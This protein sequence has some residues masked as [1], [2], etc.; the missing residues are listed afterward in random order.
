MPVNAPV[1][2][3]EQAS[4]E[5]LDILS[6]RPGFLIRRLHQIH[7]ALFHDECEAF[8]LTPVQF[9]VITAL[10]DEELDQKQLGQKVGIDRASTTDVL[11]R[12]EKAGLIERRKC[13]E[14]G[15][16]QLVRLT[17]E[18]ESLL[19]KVAGSALRAHKRTLQPLTKAERERFIRYM[20][21]IVS[22]NNE[23]GRASLK[24]S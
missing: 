7:V 1:T 4:E 18:G 16:R 24:L 11:R 19:T 2:A 12:L 23:H 20:R 6:E 3:A 13:P 14:D 17:P 8:G 22:A 10:E 15:R 9:S 21:K 5:R